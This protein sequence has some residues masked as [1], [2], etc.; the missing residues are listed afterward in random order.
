MTRILSVLGL[1]CPNCEK[2]NIFQGKFLFGYHKM[3]PNCTK[4]NQNF[5][6]E[7]GFFYGAM[8]V[9]YVLAVAESIATYIICQF[10]FS[11][12]FDMR[13]LPFII[14]VIIILSPINYKFS[15][16]L[17]LYMFIKKQPKE[18]HS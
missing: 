18:I 7:P 9:S 15:R 11:E 4:C 14:G 17:W 2:A 3:H 16:A 8:Y 10:F 12:T 5:V 13:I 6:M 1:K